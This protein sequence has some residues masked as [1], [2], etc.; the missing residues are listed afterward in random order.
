MQSTINPVINNGSPTTMLLTTF[1]CAMDVERKS[2]SES[3]GG[4][5]GFGVGPESSG[6]NC[7]NP[8]MVNKMSDEVFGYTDDCGRWI[9][10]DRDS[11][12]VVAESPDDCEIISWY[13]FKKDNPHLQYS[14]AAVE[15]VKAI[16]NYG[17]GGN[18]YYLEFSTKPDAD[19]QWS[20]MMNQT[21]ESEVWCPNDPAVAHN[22]VMS[23]QI[24]DRLPV[25]NGNSLLFLSFL[26]FIVLIIPSTIK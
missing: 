19:F 5:S 2:E 20:E 25:A 6:M 3:G 7:T 21:F 16:R 22:Q 15:L 11:S 9:V 18:I 17:N 26:H 23:V 13:F 24:V 4:L 8:K 12:N 10:F 14:T 1:W